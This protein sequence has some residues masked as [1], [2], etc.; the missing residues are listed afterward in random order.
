[1]RVTRCR[2]RVR[3]I[4]GRVESTASPRG[5]TTVHRFAGLMACLGACLLFEGPAAQPT[6]ATLYVDAAS[7]CASVCTL[8]GSVCDP[9]CAAGCGT[10]GAPY[11]SIQSAVND[12]NCRVATGGAAT[13]SV[14]VAAG[15]YRDRIFVFPNTHDLG[16]GAGASVIDA[17]G[18]GRSAVIFS[19]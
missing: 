1:L 18:Q 9:G 6:E 16:A 8:T 14:R 19:R 12:A 15:L 5:L 2:I 11:R 3:A 7:P 10:A 4:R 13:V 17:T